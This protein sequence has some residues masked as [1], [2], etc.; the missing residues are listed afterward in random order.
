MWLVDHLSP[1]V[2][3]TAR[4]PWVAV[5]LCRAWNAVG[6]VAA[7]ILAGDDE[8]PIARAPSGSPQFDVAAPTQPMASIVNQPFA[9]DA[10]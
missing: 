4:S 3:V 10:A 7:R 5:A 9:S 8:Q 1:S 2:S 6:W